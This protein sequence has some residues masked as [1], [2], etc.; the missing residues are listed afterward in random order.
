M[1]SVLNAAFRNAHV[2]RRDQHSAAVGADGGHGARLCAAAAEALQGGVADED[3]EIVQTPYLPEQLTLPAE[4]LQHTEFV[5]ALSIKNL[6][7]LA[8]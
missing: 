6:E 1:P 3:K 8:A 5:I 7:L 4:V 2:R